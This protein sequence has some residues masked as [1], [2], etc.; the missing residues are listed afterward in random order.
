MHPDVE[1]ILEST[2][3]RAERAE[4]R[5]ETVEARDFRGAV[6]ATETRGRNPVIGEVKPSSPTMGESGKDPVETAR[7]MVE[8]GAAAISVLTEPEH[9]AGSLETLR[10]V[11]EAVNV[12]VLRKDFILEPR[13]LYEVEA[14]LILLIAAFLE[15]EVLQELV[16]QAVQIGFEPL[17]EV[18][19]PEELLVALDTEARVVGVNN[20][21]L[22]RLEVDLSVG[23]RLLPRIPGARIA[24]AESGISSPN[25]LHRLR[26]AGA[27]AFLVGTSIMRSD[28]VERKTRLLV[29]A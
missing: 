15:D 8:G 25:D 10:E 27:D 9:F 13:Q 21:D 7:A 18:H 14:D 23:E 19:T 22:S 24:V 6:E 16:S 17:V 3:R 26:A 29:E 11:R 5:V 2:R 1:A 12:P 20:R 28:D 4:R